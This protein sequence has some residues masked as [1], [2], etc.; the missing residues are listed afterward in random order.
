MEAR[1]KA[2]RVGGGNMLGHVCAIG[3]YNKPIMKDAF[4]MQGHQC[5]T[6]CFDY[7]MHVF[8]LR[9]LFHHFLHETQCV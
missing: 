3:Q 6:S 1:D 7:S 5:S 8:Y 2:T 9:R 4:N